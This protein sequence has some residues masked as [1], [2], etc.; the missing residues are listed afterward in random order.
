MGVPKNNDKTAEIQ[1]SVR[2]DYG[3][4]M[5]VPKNNDKKEGFSVL[6]G[7]TTD[8]YWTSYSVRIFPGLLLD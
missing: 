1:F 7:P 6:S 2:T 5:D 4:L 3:S 8:L